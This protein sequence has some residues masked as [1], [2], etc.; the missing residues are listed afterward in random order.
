[1]TEKFYKKLVKVWRE[2]RICDD[3]IK[4]QEDFYK[5]NSELINKLRK[6]EE[7]ILESDMR[8]KIIL[9]MRFLLQDTMLLRLTKILEN[10]KEIKE[11]DPSSITPEE[12]SFLTIIRNGELFGNNNLDAP[13][14][15]EHPLSVKRNQFKL[16]RM[17]DDLPAIVGMDLV[18]Y[19]P[20]KKEDI[21][22][23]PYDNAKIL[24]TKELAME[25]HSPLDM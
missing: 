21:V 25:I 16:V 20:F 2:N 15:N 7:N 6:P 18:T 3:L 5:R 9:R 11:L 4:I 10:I 22:L 14:G 1:M 12:V 19:G 23:I 17:L 24:V 13:L 8:A